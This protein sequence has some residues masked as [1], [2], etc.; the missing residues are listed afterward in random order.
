MAVDLAPLVE[1]LRERI[2]TE[3]A[4]LTRMVEL[5]EIVRFAHSIGETHPIYLDEA[6]ARTT[7]FGAVIAPPTFVSVFT[8]EA[9]TGVFDRDMPFARFLHTDD[10]VENHR[11]IRAGDVITAQARFV[12]VFTRTGRN[13]EMLFQGADMTLTNQDGER[14]A[15]VRVYTVYFD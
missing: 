8:P 7:R 5:G 1:R 6:Y 2:G 10:V 4:A 11:P 14:V 9:F 3:G 12:D 13:G 15:V